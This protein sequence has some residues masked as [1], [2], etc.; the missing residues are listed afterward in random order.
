MERETIE[1]LRQELRSVGSA[2][3]GQLEKQAASS[4]RVPQPP[5]P[6]SSQEAHSEVTGTDVSVKAK[7][8]R[9]QTHLCQNWA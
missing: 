7:V 9:S 8:C 2:S 3:V 4:I 6:I 5:R 1:A